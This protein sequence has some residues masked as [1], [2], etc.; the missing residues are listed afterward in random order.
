MVSLP[1]RAPKQIPT[2]PPKQ[3]IAGPTP[4]YFKVPYIL[5]LPIILLLIRDK[6]PNSP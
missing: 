3:I 5:R 1:P 4:G 6:G 2:I